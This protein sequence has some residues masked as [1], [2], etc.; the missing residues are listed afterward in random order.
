M[1][2]HEDSL[3]AVRI[4]DK[5][6]RNRSTPRRIELIDEILI[7]LDVRDIHLK[8]YVLADKERENFRIDLVGIIYAD[9]SNVHAGILIIVVKLYNIRKLFNTW[10]APGCPYIEEKN[11]AV[12]DVNKVLNGDLDPFV[13]AYL[14]KKLTDATT[15]ATK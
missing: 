7:F 1:P 5:G 8:R 9:G 10:L 6:C 3:L 11:F 13:E 14:R 12:S 15:A 4:E 2:E